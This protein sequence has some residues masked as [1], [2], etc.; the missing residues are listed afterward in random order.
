M[1]ILGAVAQCAIYRK[2]VEAVISCKRKG[3]KKLLIGACSVPF[4]QL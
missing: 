4:R 1:Q 3:R 2:G